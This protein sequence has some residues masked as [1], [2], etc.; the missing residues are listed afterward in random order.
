MTG[1]EQND[2]YCVEIMLD[3]GAVTARELMR[4]HPIDQF[5]EDA[6]LAWIAS[7]LD[8]GLIKVKDGTGRGTRYDLTDKGSAWRR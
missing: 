6:A 1:I 2:S 8:R 5:E 3:H 4:A 7:A